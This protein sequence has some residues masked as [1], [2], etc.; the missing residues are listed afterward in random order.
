MRIIQVAGWS[1]SGKTTFIVEL[2]AA[3]SQLGPVGTIKH[4]ADH[5]WEL[6]PGK[7]T[8]NHYQAG[9]MITGGID[10][11]KS[12]LTCRTISLWDCLSL[13]SDSGIRYA[14]VEGFKAVPFQKVVIGSPDIP[15]LMRDPAVQDVIARIND[16]DE[17]YTLS[18]LCRELEAESG[19]GVI[20]SLSG[21]SQVPFSRAAVREMEQRLYA[22]PGVLSGRFRFNPRIRGDSVQFFLLVC[23]KTPENTISA[24]SVAVNELSGAYPDL[25]RF[26]GG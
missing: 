26:E 17:F 6:Q 22:Y 24:L 1:G 18:G 21:Y 19:S 3:L 4:I 11:E 20:L 9:A 16:F 8:T 7:D 2:V 5:V 10:Q 12:M 13:L 15:A 23:A 14:V 25:F